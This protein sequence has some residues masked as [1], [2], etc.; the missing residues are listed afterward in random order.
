MTKAI[1]LHTTASVCLAAVVLLALPGCT[2][3]NAEPSAPA[4]QAKAERKANTMAF[5][6]GDKATSAV[7]LEKRM[8]EQIFMG[9]S[10]GYS[11]VVTNLTDLTLE[12]IRIS[13]TLP[14]NFTLSGSSPYEAVMQGATAVWTIPSIPPHG[15]VTL[16]INGTANSGAQ[17]ATCADVTYRSQLCAAAPI[18]SPAIALAVTLAPTTDICT[19]TPIVYTVTN[20]GSATLTN[21]TV[22]PAI[23]PGLKVVRGETSFHVNSLAPGA[24]ESFTVSVKPASSGEH[25]VTPTASSSE[26][27]TATAT[28]TTTAGAPVLAASASVP[29]E[30]LIV[31]DITYQ[32][33]V[34]NTGTATAGATT[35]TASMPATAK[36]ISA[37]SGG[38]EESGNV[39]WQLSGLNAGGAEN[40]SFTVKPETGG[41]FSTAVKVANDCA[42]TATAAA[43]TKV[44]G[45]PALLLEAIDLNDPVAVGDNV[46]YQVTVTNQGSA[47]ATNV[48]LEVQLED[49][50]SYV[51]SD[52]ETPGVAAGQNI[53]FNP[54]SSIP[55]GGKA[56]YSVTVR[57]V[58]AGDV[59]FKVTLTANEL[60]R[61][62]SETESTHQY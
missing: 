31:H 39:V 52:G 34:K 49:N 22:N 53:K 3:T 25:S 15:S 61:P 51:S 56:V 41:V 12:A 1:L 13:E 54:I 62:V 43:E 60:T 14:E 36:F 5:P 38:R 33:G 45:I 42:G 10:F 9:K 8:P 18:V 55:I 2:T 17:F 4:P 48:A 40:Y 44:V 23:P 20:S 57:A 58:S 47:P 27:V 35:V 16:D 32:I 28:A 59:R 37:S 46:V 6:T 24:A 50:Q 21:V 11:M 26:G 19:E 30:V 7:L 29:E